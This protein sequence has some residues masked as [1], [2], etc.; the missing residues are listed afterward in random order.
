MAD[1]NKPLPA[2]MVAEPRPDFIE[3]ST[4]KS[5]PTLAPVP[6]PILPCSVDVFLEFTQAEYPIAASGRTAGTPN[7]PDRRSQLQVQL[8]LSQ[9]Q[10][11]S[12]NRVPQDNA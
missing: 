12:Q 9:H 7:E 2:S 1:T 11:H 10:Y 6:A 3:F 5:F 8:E 4:P